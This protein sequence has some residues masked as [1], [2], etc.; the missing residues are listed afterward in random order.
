M[1]GRTPLIFLDTETTGVHRDRRP[2][3]IALIRRTATAQTRLLLCVDIRDL[4]L[5]AADATGLRISG[6]HRRHPQAR[7]RP[8]M[9][10]RVYRARDAVDMVHEWTADA[11]IVGV[12]PSFD[13]ECLAAMFARHG[14]EP[15]WNDDLVDVVP[16]AAAA[17]R[18]AGREPEPDFTE[19]SRQCGV[20]PPSAAQRHTALGDARW[21]M[22]WYDRLCEMPSQRDE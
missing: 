5:P 19:L 14:V 3:E 1:T 2:W 7:D 13:T 21:A 16:L 6:F 8:L 12:V 15:K 11:T 18:A 10:P 20:K 17:I 22:R 4:D 9:I